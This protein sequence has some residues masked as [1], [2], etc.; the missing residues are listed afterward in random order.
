M[1]EDARKAIDEVLANWVEGLRQGDVAALNTLC[2]EDAIQLP[3]DR[4]IIRGR[5][6][7]K[8]SH[9]EAVQ[10]G[11][12]DAIITERELSVSGDI[13]YETG[14]Y[15]EKFHPEGKEPFEIKGKYLIIYKH[16]ADGWKIHREIWNI[17]PPQQ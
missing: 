3:P 12:K 16:T 7:I 17:L 10:M 4:E 14:N 2:T 13:A 6:K 8:E 11:V 5:Q 1:T 15:I 9:A